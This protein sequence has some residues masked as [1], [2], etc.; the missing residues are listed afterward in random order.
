M[1]VPR[2]RLLFWVAAVVLPFSLLGAVV[3]AT[4]VVSIVFIAGFLIL[5]LADMLSAGQS[6][7]GLGLELPTIT[8]ASK[9]RPARLEIMIHNDRKDGRRLRAALAWPPEIAPDVEEM[10]IELPAASEW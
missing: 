10:D 5:A 2:S 6:L 3:P 1:I 9:D 7:A 4:A 8:R